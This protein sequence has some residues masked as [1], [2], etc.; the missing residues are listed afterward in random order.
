MY[1]NAANPI[2]RRIVN[3]ETVSAAKF[4]I[5]SPVSMAISFGISL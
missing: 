1:L 3:T 4:Y 2:L 5:P